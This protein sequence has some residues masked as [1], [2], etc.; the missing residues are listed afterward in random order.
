MLFALI[1]CLVKIK[2]GENICEGLK[3]VFM[4]RMGKVLLSEIFLLVV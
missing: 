4:H 2:F 1:L 3:K